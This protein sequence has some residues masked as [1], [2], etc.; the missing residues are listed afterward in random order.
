MRIFVAGA[1]GAMGV[2]L[3]RRLVAAGH[4][5]TG[6]TRSE[7][8]RALLEGLGA[9][10]AVADVFDRERLGDVLREARPEAVV[11]LLTALPKQGPSRP[12]D[13]VATNRLRTEGTK[14][15]VEA[16]IAAGARRLVAESIVLVYGYGH[17]GPELLTEESPVNRTAPRP[18]LQP[19]LDAGLALEETVLAA[20][21]AGRIEGIVLRFGFIYGP[22]AGSSTFAT[23]LIQKRRMPLVGD[24]G[25][26]WSW[27]HLEDAAEA[28]L[29]ALEKGRSGEVYN[30]V[31]DEPVAWRDYLPWYAKVLGAPPPRRVP[32][33]LV[34]LVM[35][36]G[37]LSLTSRFAVSNA[38]ARREL[39][40]RPAHP[41]YR[42]G[43][44]PLGQRGP[45]GRGPPC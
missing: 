6:L 19:T 1:T 21:R 18:W 3:V 10:V 31:D 37:A 12:A 15:L 23:G 44:A 4:Q 24:G 32:V 8:K 25:G 16:A 41:T 34:R 22:E 26:V 29:A 43:L 30:I 11:H 33:W 17:T 36:Y 14:S 20:A 45:E 27:I 38:K 7:Q 5:V 13:L 42:E 35:P 40:W 2:P 9:S 39:G 28:T